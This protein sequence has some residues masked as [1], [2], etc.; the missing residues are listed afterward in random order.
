VDCDPFV[1][2]FLRIAHGWVA[3]DRA[4]VFARFRGFV[5]LEQEQNTES[6]GQKHFQIPGLRDTPA[7]S[8]FFVACRAPVCSRATVVKRQL[9]A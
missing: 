4:A 5:F 8:C 6:E 9:A 1:R 2:T 3:V 7:E